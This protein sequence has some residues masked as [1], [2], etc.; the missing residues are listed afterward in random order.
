MTPTPFSRPLSEANLHL[1]PLLADP[2]GVGP[3]RLRPTPGDFIVEEI[4]AYVPS[5]TGD[6]WYLWVEKEGV[7]TPAVVQQ[8]ARHA[9]VDIHDVGAAGNKD[10]QG[11]TRQ[12]LSVLRKPGFDP[13]TITLDNATILEVS[14]HNNKLRV[15]H[16]H[17]N[18]F[19]LTLTGELDAAQMQSR[20]DGLADAG[21]A[22]AFGWQRFGHGNRTLDEAERWLH[23]NAPARTRRE[24]FWV[25]AVQSAIFNSW[26]L[27]RRDAGCAFSPIDGDIL[28]KRDS[29]APFRCDDVET[30]AVRCLNKEIA[31]GGP[32]PGQRMRVAS[33]DSLVWEARAAERLGVDGTALVQLRAFEM[34]DRRIA[35]AW[36]KEPTVSQDGMRTTLS[37]G[38]GS[39]CYAT[40]LLAELIG[41]R[42]VD[43]ASPQAPVVDAKADD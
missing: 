1:P 26:L 7:S 19:I 9:Q 4:P 25:S 36:P 8:L 5:G 40:V 27:L 15:G 42:L 29:H 39:G 14:R 43:E 12:W 3:V 28:L 32:L 6:H 18:R 20:L 16:L 33:R 30:D 31:P 22:N 11:R 10:E 37:F 13:H 24:R 34:G 23:R 41:S 21:F 17:G 38:L 35:R 2:A